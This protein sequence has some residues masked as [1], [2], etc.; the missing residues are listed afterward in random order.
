M[1]RRAG[2]RT[3]NAGWPGWAGSGGW[4]AAGQSTLSHCLPRRTQTSGCR[5]AWQTQSRAQTDTSPRVRTGL[6]TPRREH[7]NAHTHTRSHR[8]NDRRRP[9]AARSGD[10]GGQGQSGLSSTLNPFPR[11][12]TWQAEQRAHAGGQS[13][14]PRTHA[15]TRAHPPIPSPFR[16]LGI[17]QEREREREEEDPAKRPHRHRHR[18]RYQHQHQHQHFFS[19]IPD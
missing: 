10:R 11:W 16:S 4:L 7:A 18:H 15:C 9:S 8:G 19:R 6:V 1:A 14:Q 17:L 13:A 2:R 5:V 12:H 3:E